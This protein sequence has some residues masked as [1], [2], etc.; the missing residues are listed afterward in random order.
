MN[1][2]RKLLYV[3]DLLRI[4][5]V[6]IKCRNCGKGEKSF[7]LIIENPTEDLSAEFIKIGEWHPL[8]EK[9]PNKVLEFVDSEKELF[10]KG[11]KAENHALG[12]GA[13]TYYRR[14]VENIKVMLIDKIIQKVDF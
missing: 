2:K 10:L 12:I 7:Y 13:Y 1:I 3:K 4:A 9:T 8:G 11:R 14:V 6:K 5:G